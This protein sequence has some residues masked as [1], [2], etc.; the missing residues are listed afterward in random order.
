MKKKKNHFQTIFYLVLLLVAVVV[1]YTQFRQQ[2]ERDYPVRLR[3]YG[4]YSQ[5][6]GPWMPLEDTK[7]SAMKGDL[8]LRGNFGMQIPEDSTITFY[9]FHLGVSFEVNGKVLA[10]T[11]AQDC[12][13]AR[14]ITVQTPLIAQGDE[15]RIRLVN[16]HSLGN[17]QAYKDLLESFYLGD[18]DMVESAVNDSSL[19]RRIAGIS[20]IVFA[21]ALLA[22]ALV[23]AVLRLPTGKRLWTIGLMALCFGGYLCF[24]SPAA[25]LDTRWSAVNTCALYLC[26]IMVAFILGVMLCEGLTSY[27]KRF[28]STMIRIQGTVL[29]CIFL[30]FLFGWIELCDILELWVPL[31]IS[32]ALVLLIL[33]LAQWQSR[34]RKG[35]GILGTSGILLLLA[36]LEVANEFLLLWP[37]RILIDSGAALFFFSYAVHGAVSVPLSFRDAAQTE[38]LRADLEHSRIVLAMSQIRAHFIFNVL[39]AISGMCKYDPGKADE[40]IIRFAR[41]LRGNIDVM[42]EDRT[43]SFLVTLRHLEDYVALEQIRFGDHIAFEVEPEV[44]D[45]KLPPLIIQPIV[46]NA[47]K[48]GLNPKEEGGFILLRTRREN[49]GV[50]ITVTD[51]GVGFDPNAK[52]DK[53]S[54]G[55]S[56]VRFR[57]KEMVNGELYI[58]S[59]PDVGTTVTIFIPEGGNKVCE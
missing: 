15:V 37:Q 39:N 40:T 26:V 30:C 4:E 32:C 20:V 27:R 46:E 48:H 43:E 33:S 17:A 45:F 9:S 35:F 25:A 41:Y 21:L 59:V 19:S 56:N 7:I 52:T 31:Q 24:I 34:Q 23:F 11:S 28:A 55:L 14:W 12:S 13:Y 29:L 42:Q 6:N 44:T 47:I 51:D 16:H 49:G 22:I 57:L 1:L 38:K 58:N 36:I 3:F 10:R 8:I 18:R 54:V 2:E 53:R 50:I 5:D